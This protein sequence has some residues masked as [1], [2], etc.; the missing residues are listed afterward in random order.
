[1]RALDDNT[2]VSAVT[3][4]PNRLLQVVTLV[5]TVLVAWWLVAPLV[6]SPGDPAPFTGDDLGSAPVSAADTRPVSSAERISENGFRPLS[7]SRSFDG[8]LYFLPAPPQGSS[9]VPDVTSLVDGRF[10][11]RTLGERLPSGRGFDAFPGEPGERREVLIPTVAGLVIVT[12]G[13]LRVLDQRLESETIDLGIG[14]AAMSTPDRASLWA[15]GSAERAVRLIDLADGS[16]TEWF[17]INDV[18]RPVAAVG[19]GLLV[20]TLGRDDAGGYVFWLPDA[21]PVPL[22]GSAG[23]DFAG[24]AG[25]RVVFHGPEG[26]QIHDVGE[27]DDVWRSDGPSTLRTSALSPSGRYLA[28]DVVTPLDEPNRI[29]VL[30]LETG[31]TVDSIETALEI[32]YQWS[33]DSSLLYMRPEWPSFTL[34]ERSVTTGADLDLVFFPD[35]SW[36]YAGAR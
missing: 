33:D 6:S 16:T 14:L 34:V 22:P 26:F 13:E 25:D 27:F 31:V 21:D 9:F 23:L 24:A 2:D 5:L 15:F 35:L 3:R 8:Q 10:V 32:G 36:W 11:D 28:H 12:N 20:S 17:D 29:D 4:A 19:D 30:D 1:M 18:G 7:G